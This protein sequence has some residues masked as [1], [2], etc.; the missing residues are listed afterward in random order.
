MRCSNCAV[1][2][3]LEDSKEC[4]SCAGEAELETQIARTEQ[5]IQELNQVK[6]E[7]QQDSHPEESDGRRLSDAHER[8]ILGF[9]KPPTLTCDRLGEVRYWIRHVSHTMGWVPEGVPDRVL[10]NWAVPFLEGRALSHWRRSEVEGTRPTTWEQLLDW[11][12]KIPPYEH[13]LRAAELWTEAKQRPDQSCLDFYYSM[14]A[15]SQDL[16][17]PF[18]MEL[19]TDFILTKML[20]SVRQKCMRLASPISNGY[21]LHYFCNMVDHSE[22]PECSDGDTRPIVLGSLKHGNA[23]RAHKRRLRRR[24]KRKQCV[25]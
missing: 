16:V 19:K 6:L 15:L 1:K 2:E 3:R 4:A 24:N 20:P 13:R 10:F 11:L 25:D 12:M 5:E 7:P 17:E 14:W 8:G 23:R 9:V 18:P 21:D 22:F